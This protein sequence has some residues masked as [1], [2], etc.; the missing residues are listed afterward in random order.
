MSILTRRVT[1]S[2]KLVLPMG[3]AV[4]TVSMP[5]AMANAMATLMYPTPAPRGPRESMGGS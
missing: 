1:D 3:V 2:P 4:M 5:E